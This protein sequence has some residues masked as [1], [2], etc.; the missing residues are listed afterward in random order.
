MALPSQPVR[1]AA[2]VAAYL[3]G[4]DLR[5]IGAAFGCSH[6]WVRLQVLRA[7]HELRPRGRRPVLDRPPVVAAIRPLH[8]EGLGAKAHQQ[9][10]AVALNFSQ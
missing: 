9:H 3:D 1:N 6:E 8:G 4:F 7:G 10:D 5:A 2:M